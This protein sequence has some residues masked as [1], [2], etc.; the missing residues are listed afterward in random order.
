MAGI[1]Y[2]SMTEDPIRNQKRK[3]YLCKGAKQTL[4][5]HVD[6]TLIQHVDD[7]VF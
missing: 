1:K 6:Q 3:L 7:Q 5:Q 4:I 2:L